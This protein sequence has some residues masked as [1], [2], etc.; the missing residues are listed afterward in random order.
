[1][2]Y[3]GLAPD[4]EVDGALRMKYAEA[5]VHLKS[6]DLLAWSHERWGSWYDFKVQMVRVFTRSVYCHVGICWVVGGR[7]FALEAVSAGVRIF[8]LSRLLPFYWVPLRAS[9]ESE[10]EAWALRQVGEPYSQWQAVLAGLGLLK[11]GEDL[12]WQ[13]AEYAA[14]VA[15]RA[16][17]ELGADVTPN[18]L[19]LAAQKLHGS[20]T[21][22][23]ED[24]A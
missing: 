21:H 9:W 17:V 2:P 7:V 18:A 20:V 5:R 22:L 8:P 23:V 19:V 24:G 3:R 11:P 10:V 12:I 13:C 4:D 6:G 15:R 14:E 16:G 1:M